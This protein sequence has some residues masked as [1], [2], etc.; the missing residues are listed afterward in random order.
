MV[1]LRSQRGEK[2]RPSSISLSPWK[3]HSCRIINPAWIWIWL[4]NLPTSGVRIV[5]KLPWTHQ[6]IVTRTQS[7]YCHMHNGNMFLCTM[8]FFLCCLQNA[9]NIKRNIYNQNIQNNKFL[10]GTECAKYEKATTILII[11]KQC[12]SVSAIVHVQNVKCKLGTVMR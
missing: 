12:K 9:N 6:D 10:Q 7:D 11:I 1:A 2:G 3:R 4:G 8:K 5:I